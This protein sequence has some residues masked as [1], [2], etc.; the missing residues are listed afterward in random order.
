[1]LATEKPLLNTI[2]KYLRDHFHFM[3]PQESGG[4]KAAD[5]LW[6]DPHL[7]TP[8]RSGDVSRGN[9]PTPTFLA[10]LF[11]TRMTLSRRIWQFR[12]L[13]AAAPVLRL[14]EVLVQSAVCCVCAQNTPK[15]TCNLSINCQLSFEIRNKKLYRNLEYGNKVTLTFAMI[16][17]W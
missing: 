10:H 6:K 13:G 11:T 17:A 7:L 2:T 3:W 16:A 15:K 9:A 8:Q 14:N 4:K 1:M 5:P 12:S